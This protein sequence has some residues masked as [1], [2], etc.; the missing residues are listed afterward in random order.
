MVDTS[1][2]DKLWQ[3]ETI[4]A[5]IDDS[6]ERHRKA[7]VTLK[8][9]DARGNPLPAARV[10]VAQ[11]GS[12]FLFGS[13]IFMFGGYDDAKRNGKYEQR[14]VHMFNAATVPLY[15]KG[16]EPTRG[17]L[18]FEANSE[19]VFRR[20]PPDLTVS[21]CEAHGLNMNGHCLVWDNPRHSVPEWIEDTR[22]CEE[23]IEKRI[24]EIGERYGHRIQRWDVLNES[25]A[26][27]HAG[28]DPILPDDVEWLAFQC[29]MQY[30]PE[31]A[32]LMINETVGAAWYRKHRAD[33]NKQIDA[34]RKRGAKIDGVGLQ[35]HLFGDEAIHRVLA[36]EHLTPGGMFE[37]LDE[38][39]QHDLPVH[40]S[41][42]TLPAFDDGDEARQ[43]QARMVRDMYRLWFSHPAVH[44]ITWWNLP[45]GG[46]VP[47]EDH[48]KSGMID[49]QLDPKPVYEMM[50]ELL[51]HEWRTNTTVETDADGSAGFRGFAGTYDL[52][53]DGRAQTV[54][55]HEGQANEIAVNVKA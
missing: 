49:E 46:A 33:Y 19:P 7:D 37:A 16:L 1:V 20:P 54:H 13:N 4:R 48:L 51:H 43:L 18:R 38:Y 21:F 2:Y 5:R 35:W 41:E 23:L 47:G 40:I 25:L 39:L 45:D 6:I 50:D 53:V 17:N 30:L 22:H 14:F 9:T 34:M 36:G 10:E 55:V 42:I 32:H 27:A 29:A 28:L 26:R 44:A 52:K 8:V 12:D 15:W 31:S 24:R 11:T 3:D